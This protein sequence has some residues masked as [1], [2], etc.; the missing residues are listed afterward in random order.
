VA[1]FQVRF[2]CRI[3]EHKSRLFRRQYADL[4]AAGMHAQLRCKTQCP[5]KHAQAVVD[6]GTFLSLQAVA[7]EGF[8]LFKVDVCQFCVCDGRKSSSRL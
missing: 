6:R 3:A 7:G 5:A 4:R 2:L 8:D 1:G